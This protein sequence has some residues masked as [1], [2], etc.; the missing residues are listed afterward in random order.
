MG[1]DPHSEMTSREILRHYRAGA[2][3][4]QRISRA[5]LLCVPIGDIT[6]GG[7]GAMAHFV[8]PRADFP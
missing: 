8:T 7:G 5:S 3:E 2:R 4:S 1:L 6:I